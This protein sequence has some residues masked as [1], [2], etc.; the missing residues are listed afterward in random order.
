MPMPMPMPIAILD[1]ELDRALPPFGMQIVQA[2]CRT[3]SGLQAAG[4]S[5]SS[6]LLARGFGRPQLPVSPDDSAPVEYAIV[7]WARHT[8]YRRPR[9]V[10]GDAVPECEYGEYE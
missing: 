9:A 10:N 5:K 7:S 6:T 1:N 3:S 2:T 8:G 4:L